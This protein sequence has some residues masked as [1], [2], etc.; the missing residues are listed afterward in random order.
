MTSLISEV[1]KCTLSEAAREDVAE[2]K[3]IMRLRNYRD[4]K[5]AFDCATKDSP[6]SE[7]VQSS[8]AARIYCA[9]R[10]VTDARHDLN[11]GVALLRDLR[12]GSRDV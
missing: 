7:A 2:C 8:D 5:Q 1:F 11:E 4:V 6:A 10:Y 9:V 12:E 3:R